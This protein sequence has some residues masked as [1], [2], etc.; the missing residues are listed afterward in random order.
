ML[1]FIEVGDRF[2]AGRFGEV[3]LEAVGPSVVFAGEDGGGSLAVRHDGVCAVAADVVEAVDGAVAVADEE[4]GEVGYVEGEV[5]ACFGEAGGI[6][7]QHPALGEDGTT[8]ELVHGFGA[9]P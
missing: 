6:G 1:G 2:K 4:E 3:P 9:V 8:L 7:E 5:V